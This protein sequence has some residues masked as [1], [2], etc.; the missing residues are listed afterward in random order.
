M[1][2]ISYRIWNVGSNARDDLSENFKQIRCEVSTQDI[3]LF[4]SFEISQ[5]SLLFEVFQIK[6]MILSFFN[7]HSSIIF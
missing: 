1:Q 6:L 3:I 5:N 7:C 4:K 2:I